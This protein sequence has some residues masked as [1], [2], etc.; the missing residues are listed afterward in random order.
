[1]TNKCQI[2][3]RSLQKVTSHVCNKHKTWEAL[4]VTVQSQSKER[5]LRRRKVL[6][7]L[8]L[9]FLFGHLS[10]QLWGENT[11]LAKLITEMQEARNI[12]KNNSSN[13]SR[14]I[15][16]QGVNKSP[17][18]PNY[19]KQIECNFYLLYF[20]WLLMYIFSNVS[21]SKLLI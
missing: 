5:F 18:Y 8:A 4:N 1:M 6:W 3:L 12:N 2:I 16:R 10:K 14:I 19:L 20:L 9:V 15:T 7:K 21:I 17:A 13:K 11:I